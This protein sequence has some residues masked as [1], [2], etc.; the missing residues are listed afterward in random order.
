[1]EGI[2]MGP[3][4]QIYQELQGFQDDCEEVAHESPV[5][6]L[7]AEATALDTLTDT[8]ADIYA[9]HPSA[10][11]DI[12]RVAAVVSD[13]SQT[14][15]KTAAKQ[16]L[17]ERS[18]KAR[19]NETDRTPLDEWVKNNL[20][21]VRVIRTTDHMDATRYVWDFGPVTLET[22]GGDEGRGHYHWIN[23]RDS[24]DEAGGPYCADPNDPYT[25]HQEW[26]NWIVTKREQRETVK[27][28]VGPRTNAVHALQDR[29]RRTDAFESLDD[30]I[31]YSG[32]HVELAGEA[33]RPDDAEPFDAEETDAEIPNWKVDT[34]YI[35]NSW[36]VEEA[37]E[38]GIST[39]ALQNEIDARG[40]MLDGH[41]KI[42]TREYVGNSYA[43]F[44]VVQGDFAT[45]A[46][47]QPEGAEIKRGGVDAL[48][49]DEREQTEDDF[50]SI[51]GD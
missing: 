3:K 17:A 24:I 1:M 51:G 28:N 48:E 25:D 16:E 10:D 46:A 44:W 4:Q 7:Q 34:I 21:E 20:R 2:L 29:V 49:A 41:S 19:N 35:P 13:V 42:A 43:T 32:V 31:N 8:L 50:G 22:E 39:R 9:E 45:P 18:Q 6:R 15:T 33:D 27:T 38:Y 5:Q 36:A 37:E 26:R 23:F 30:A 47:Y 11:P 14:V 40:Y 12:G